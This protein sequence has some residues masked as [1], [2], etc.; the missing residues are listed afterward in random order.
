MQALALSAP[1]GA[2]AFGTAAPAAR[3]DPCRASAERSA[4]RGSAYRPRMAHPGLRAPRPSSKRRE[5][6]AF[7]RDGNRRRRPCV[8]ATEP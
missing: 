4:E 3:R 7:P 1:V 2:Q 5:D 6:R 8:A